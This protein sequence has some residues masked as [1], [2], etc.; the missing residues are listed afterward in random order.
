MATTT[1]R[2]GIAETAD[3][4]TGMGPVIGAAATNAGGLV[5]LR[6]EL[7]ILSVMRCLDA[8]LALDPGFQYGYPAESAAMAGLS[9]QRLAPPL[10][11]VVDAA[12]QIVATVCRHVTG[13]R[14]S[15]VLAQLPRGL[16]VQTAS[17]VITDVLAALDAL[18]ARGV[19]HRAPDADHVIVEPNGNCVLVDVGLVTRP[20]YSDPAAAMA[21]DLEMVGDLL[22]TCLTAGRRTANLGLRTG[23][24][25]HG[26]LEGVAARLYDAIMEAGAD[27][28][29]ETEQTVVD[30]EA[31]QAPMPRTA[32][33]MSGAL[34]RVA[35]DSFDAGWDG[36]GR[37][38][39]AIAT[40][41]HRSSRR[42]FLEFRPTGYTD[43][44]W[45]IR[46]WHAGAPR[47]RRSRQRLVASADV[48]RQARAQLAE[49]WSGSPGARG[50]GNHAAGGQLGP[51]YTRYLI[52]LIAFLLAFGLALI[53]LGLS[54]SSTPG[55]VVMNPSANARAAVN[56]PNR[57][58]KD[59]PNA[60]PAEAISD[61]ALIN[62]GT[63]VSN[64]TGNAASGTKITELF[65][66]ALG[67][68]SQQ[69]SKAVATIDV[70]TSGT[71]PVTVTVSFTDTNN[72]K[73]GD[74]TQTDRFSLS[75]KTMYT[76]TDTATVLQYCSSGSRLLTSQVSV[77]AALTAAPNSPAATASGDLY[78]DQCS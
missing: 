47:E 7:G 59:L 10:S 64:V 12:G 25:A 21:A 74:G 27:A 63:A 43:H 65:I 26:E 39:L 72:A 32:A 23:Y 3:T 42:R 8:T 76:L 19:A 46:G 17:A 16:D 31:E 71:A 37:E 14:L 33:L 49:L 78:A 73:A 56:T 70:H 20:E 77:S 62:S 51:K 45:S 58:T 35:A 9:D 54:S 60:G 50:S 69:K 48:M 13:V 15:K 5:V 75:G 55:R 6:D 57:A 68:D 66:A 41:D 53:L 67:Y 30:A 2:H 28:E 40:R 4:A 24:F 29:A 61:T 36:R 44:R 38:R 52:P 22:V 18:H 11:Y 34:E 1:A